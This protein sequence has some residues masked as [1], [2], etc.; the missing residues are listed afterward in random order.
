[1]AATLSA[2]RTG[3][4]LVTKQKRYEQFCFLIF[5]CILLHFPSLQLLSVGYFLQ[6]IPL[7]ICLFTAYE[8]DARLGQR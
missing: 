6:N 3:D 4:C 5:L 1:M 2:V 8:L 7:R